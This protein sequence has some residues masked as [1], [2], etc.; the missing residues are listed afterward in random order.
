MRRVTGGDP[1]RAREATARYP[2]RASLLRPARDGA[3]VAL[4]VLAATHAAG[5]LSIGV[6]A[7][8][9]WSLDPGDP[10]SGTRPG[11][12]L[13]FFYTPA[14]AQAFAPFH[15]LPWQLFIALWSLLL[16]AALVWQAGLWTG[17][18]LLFVPVFAEIA[19][20]NIHLLL[21]AAVIIG[22]RYPA[23]WA[24]ALLTKITPGIGLLWFVVRREWRH[25]AIALGATVAIAAVSFVIA[26][27]Q[28]SRW[29]EILVAAAGAKEWPFTIPVPLWVRL[30]IA[31]VVVI[32]GARTNRRWTVPVASTIALPVLWVNGLAMLIAVLPLIPDRVGSTPA[33][34]WLAARETGD[35]QAAADPETA[36]TAETAPA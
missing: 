34:R 15:L 32:W 16:A 14:A 3:I 5:L 1:L 6:D 33:S 13:A 31:A 4:F 19:A 18:A 24:F 23:V 20:G 17:P 12:T 11:E 10:Y 22:F 27:T 9:Y 28:W 7:N 36:D 26:P 8:T 29:A 35:S 30:A 21:G 25:L 2:I